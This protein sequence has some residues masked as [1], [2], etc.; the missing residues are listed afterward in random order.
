[1]SD[2]VGKSDDRQIQN[3]TRKVKEAAR[4][5]EEDLGALK[6]VGREFLKPSPKPRQSLD[7]Q[8]VLSLRA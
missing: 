8:K 1:M 7:N 6:R 4:E 5:V 2:L 3:R